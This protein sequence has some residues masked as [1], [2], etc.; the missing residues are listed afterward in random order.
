MLS[1]EIKINGKTIYE[2]TAVNDHSLESPDPTLRK[3]DWASYQVNG[4][5]KPRLLH[6]RQ[7]GA[8]WLARL[9]I[10][11]HLKNS[12]ETGGKQQHGQDSK[13]G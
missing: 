5:E 10:E 2:L 13:R 12:K 8:L 7:N 9:L 1:V 11:D 4:E 6:N 3:Y